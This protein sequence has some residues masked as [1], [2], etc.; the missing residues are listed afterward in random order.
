MR[1]LVVA[2][3][4][5]EP[6]PLAAML[7]ADERERAARFFFERD[8]RR[9]IVARARLR[10]LL[11]ARLG[12]PPEA[13]EF[14]YGEHGKPALAPGRGQ[15]DLRFNLA[16]HEDVV[17]YAFAE[18][19]EV[20]V[21]VEAVRELDDADEMARRCFSRAEYRAYRDLAGPERAQGFFNCWTRKE[22]FIKALGDGLTY[23]LD[24]FDVSL[25][26][27]EPARILR[28]ENTPGDYCG[29]HM[30]GFSPAPG[31]VAAVVV[32][33]GRHR[34]ASATSSEG[35]EQSGMPGLYQAVLERYASP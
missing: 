32:E 16:H 13:L 3:L 34:A 8:R 17:M 11:G 24:R 9:Y 23:P 6:R 7:C 15:R 19:A 5:V 30:E 25:A 31:L 22:A 21:D 18:G 2:S 29:W 27:G 4:N 28:V 20:G 1:E 35:R 10:Q 33:S 12:V 26:P 14:A